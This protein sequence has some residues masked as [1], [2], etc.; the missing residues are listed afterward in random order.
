MKKTVIALT[1]FLNVRELWLPG[2]KKEVSTTTAN[3]LLAAGLVT[4]AEVEIGE[5]EASQGAEVSPAPVPDPAKRETK[6]AKVK[7]ETK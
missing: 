3:E 5:T 7:L 4:E 6:P 2:D 1:T